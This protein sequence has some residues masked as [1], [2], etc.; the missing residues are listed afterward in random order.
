VRDH[1]QRVR[2]RDG[3]GERTSMAAWWRIGEFE[4]RVLIFREV[5]NFTQG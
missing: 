3:R 4:V 2:E 1:R 5:V